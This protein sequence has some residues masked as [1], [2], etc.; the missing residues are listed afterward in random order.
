[1]SFP[2]VEQHEVNLKH[3]SGEK[4]RKEEE[5]LFILYKVTVTIVDDLPCIRELATSSSSGG[6]SC[7][8]V[9]ADG[10]TISRMHTCT[11]TYMC[12]QV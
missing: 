2:V 1:M 4:Q 7:K 8:R 12:A 3:I 10:I 5:K 6:S 9:S 11:H